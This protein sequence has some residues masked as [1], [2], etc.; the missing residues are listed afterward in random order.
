MSNRFSFPLRPSNRGSD[1]GDDASRAEA[2][3]FCDFEEFMLKNKMTPNLSPNPEDYEEDKSEYENEALDENEYED[4]KE[5][6]PKREKVYLVFKPT[7]NR[8]AASILLPALIALPILLPLTTVL[9]FVSVSV[10][11]RKNWTGIVLIVPFVIVLAITLYFIYYTISSL[12]NYRHTKYLV[13]SKRVIWIRGFFKKKCNKL[14]YRQINSIA[15]PSNTKNT[16]SVNLY[17]ELRPMHKYAILIYGVPK[18]WK[19]G[20]KLIAV[21]KAVLLKQKPN[22]NFAPDMPEEKSDVSYTDE[23]RQD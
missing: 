20:S 23:E 6:V 4:E 7:F 11:T 22:F 10:F 15:S 17:T 5:F 9:G 16:V 8:Y 13:T 14:T 18:D 2:E 21:T 3:G 1:N 19:L 12:L